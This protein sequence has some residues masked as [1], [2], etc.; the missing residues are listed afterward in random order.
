ML[1]LPWDLCVRNDGKEAA[2]LMHVSSGLSSKKAPGESP[3]PVLM[4]ETF[5]GHRR[6]SQGSRDAGMGT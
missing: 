2:V 1:G 3:R 5:L 6:G 4:R